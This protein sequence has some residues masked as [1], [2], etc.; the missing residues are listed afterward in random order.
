MIIRSAEPRAQTHLYWL[1]QG[2]LLLILVGAML[3]AAAALGSPGVIRSLL[4]IRNGG[5]TVLHRERPGLALYSL[6]Q[7]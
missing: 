1:I 7:E 2:L 4:K 3:I 5:N 6:R